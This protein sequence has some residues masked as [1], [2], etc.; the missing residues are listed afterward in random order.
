M[1][2]TDLDSDFVVE[3]A[4]YLLKRDSHHHVGIDCSVRINQQMPQSDSSPKKFDFK[5]ANL[6]A[7]SRALSEI[8]WSSELN[9]NE[10]GTNVQK[11]YDI[12]N[13]LIESHVPRK[14]PH[15]NYSCEWM[16]PQLAS[17]RN[18]RNRAES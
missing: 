9:S 17:C 10:V 15:R 2:F 12:L 6:P 5:K 8:G 18:R 14:R 16:N 1:I 4:A 13:R 7:L 11:F 3:R